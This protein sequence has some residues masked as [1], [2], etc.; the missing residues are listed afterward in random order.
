M[1]ITYLSM[2]YCELSSFESPSPAVL[3]SEVDESE[4]VLQDDT[5]ES[6]SEIICDSDSQ[7][8]VVKNSDLLTDMKP[9]QNK[10]FFVGIGG[11]KVQVTHRG[12]LVKLGIPT[13][14][15]PGASSNI[16]SMPIMVDRN[17]KFEMDSQKMNIIYDGIVH[18]T[19]LRNQKVCWTSNLSSNNTIDVSLTVI[20]RHFTPEQIDRAKKVRKPHV[21]LG[22][23]SDTNLCRLLDNGTLHNCAV[24]ST[25]VK[26]AQIILGSKLFQLPREL[27]RRNQPLRLVSP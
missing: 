9:M 11:H 21:C 25:D 18:S 20:N 4:F 24:T 15:A 23:P 17:F 10:T 7:E 1:T 5:T 2:S 22:H 13:V 12:N 27:P 16:L 3:V 6:L 19:V 26:N 14:Y 8:T